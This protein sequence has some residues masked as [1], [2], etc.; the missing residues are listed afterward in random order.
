MPMIIFPTQ[1]LPLMQKCLKCSHGTL[2][3]DAEDK[4][5]KTKAILCDAPFPTYN[6]CFQYRWLFVQGR[7]PDEQKKRGRPRK[8]PEQK[9]EVTDTQKHTKS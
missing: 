3:E 6:T 8:T 2:K 5:K 4:Y 9:P 1:R 7:R